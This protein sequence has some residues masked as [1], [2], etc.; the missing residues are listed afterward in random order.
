MRNRN[1]F[2]P[3]ELATD[4]VLSWIKVSALE[5]VYNH[6]DEES[7]AFKAKVI[8]HLKK[9]HDRMLK[10]SGLDGLPIFHNEKGESK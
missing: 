8:E 3:K 6:L 10:Q 5:K 2:T 9:M 7:P 4:I 1:G